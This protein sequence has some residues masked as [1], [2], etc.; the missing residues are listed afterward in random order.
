MPLE[1]Q[2]VLVSCQT[3]SFE[4]KSDAE[5]QLEGLKPFSGRVT[6]QR[7]AFPLLFPALPWGC[8]FMWLTG[9]PRCSLQ[10]KTGWAIP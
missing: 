2:F 4:T 1:H 3:G 7:V 9:N 5:V 10:V 6:F 8:G